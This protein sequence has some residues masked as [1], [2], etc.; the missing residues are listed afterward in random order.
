MT[1]IN[2]VLILLILFCL[3]AHARDEGG[4][5]VVFTDGNQSCGQMTE[6]V[7]K[8]SCSK[9]IYSAYIDGYLSAIN[10]LSLGK[11]NFFEGTDSISRYKF[12]LKYCQENPLDKVITGI[13]KLNRQYNKNMY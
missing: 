13:D 11:A 6:D 8:Y 1:L 12:V 3:P 9:A 10:L 2:I 5:A 4:I 7:V